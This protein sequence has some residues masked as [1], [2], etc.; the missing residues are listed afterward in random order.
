MAEQK[1]ILREY[2]LGQLPAA[3]QTAFEARY[4]TDAELFAQVVDAE[5]ELVDEYAHGLLSSDTRNRFERHYLADPRRR[6]RAEF[7]A[8]LTEK[9]RQ[10]G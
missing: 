6:A 9:I 2:L 7:A 10:R 4:F 8:T 1:Q 5:N 3:E